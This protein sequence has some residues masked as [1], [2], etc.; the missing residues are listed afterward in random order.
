MAN[1]RRLKKDD[2]PVGKYSSGAT[3]K[4]VEGRYRYVQSTPTFEGTVTKGGQ[5][6]RGDKTFKIGAQEYERPK[7]TEEKKKDSKASSK[8]KSEDVVSDK[9][10]AR[11]RRRMQEEEMLR[12]MG[13]RY[14]AIM[15]SPEPGEAKPKGMAKGG[16]TAKQQAKVG[17]V[18]KE[19][20]AGS[21]HSGKGGKVVK[22][23]KQAVAIALSEARKK[24]A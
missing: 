20:K 3:D 8:K 15:P 6:T 19:F 24:K 18:M 13:E 10:A 1:Y 21:L 12:K 5:G 17:T 16:M 9:V 2:T 7:K 14:D 23:P 22:S 4:P 11:M